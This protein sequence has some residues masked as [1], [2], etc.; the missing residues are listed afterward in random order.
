[1]R[2]AKKIIRYINL[3]MKLTSIIVGFLFLIIL[4]KMGYVSLATEVDGINLT[5]MAENHYFLKETLYAQRGVIYDINGKP[6]AK[7]ANSYKLIAYLSESRTTDPENPKHVVDKDMTTEK[8]CNILSDE[9]TRPKCIEQVGRLLKQEGLYQTELS[10]WG[11]MNEDEKQK[12][13][14]LD[15]PGIDYIELEK[16][17]QYINSSWAS[18]IL[19]YARSNDDG[20]IEG[21]MGIEAYFNDELKGKNGYTEYQTDAVGYKLP[22]NE[23]FGEEAIPGEDIYLTIDSEV[24][25]ILENAVTSFTK[26]KTQQWTLFAVMDA[27]N[28]N[29]LGSATNPNFNPNTL[30]GLTSYLNPLT[31]YTYEPGSTMKTFNWLAAMENNIYKG[32]EKYLSGTLNLS[33]GTVIKDFNNVG[34]GEITYDKGFAYSSNV[35]ASNL[36]LKLGVGKLMDFYEACGFGKKTG[37]TLPGELQGTLDVVY[38][39]ELANASFGQGILVTPIQLMQALT[40]VANDGVIIKPNIVSKIVDSKGNVTYEAKRSELGSVVS[41]ENAAKIRKLMHDVV[42]DSFDYDLLYAPS[43]VEIAG[44]TGTAQIA[45]EKGGYLTGNYDYI[46]S[47]LGFFPYDNPKYIFYFATKQYVGDG[48]SISTT[49]AGAIKDIANALNATKGESD[50]DVSK[51]IELVEYAGKEVDTVR[52]ELQKKGL[53][54][55]ILG[56]G[57]Y[58]TEEYPKKG[59]KVITSS[60]VFLLTNDTNYIMPDVV[61]W[62]TNE[63]IRLCNIL[64]IKYTLKG[65]G[66]VKQTNFAT[67]EKI[68]LTK[69]MEIV[70]E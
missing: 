21:E 53:T 13:M 10:T 64:N 28:G 61:G 20:E 4:A 52:D 35:A 25:N 23:E 68:D 19:G 51:I 46:K 57:K 38:E 29:I 59:T 26:G 69:T 48:A 66:K 11:Y 34:W 45:S 47:F 5:K 17:R 14:S 8:L 33:D 15:L 60:K 36:A 32:D 49:I 65:Y 16:K 6:L 7:N 18:Y 27:K 3:N 58:V 1:M 12:V 2:K 30:D 24:Q 55:I 37:I 44:K 62:S 70:L 43:N 67:N 63:I 39:S 22:T 40:L 42:Y 50:V 9:L 31:S 41:K 54:P 56:G